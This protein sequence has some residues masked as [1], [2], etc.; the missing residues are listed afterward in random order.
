MEDEFQ[1]NGAK[2]KNIWE[3]WH[4]STASNIL[5]ILKTGYVVPPSNAAHVTGRLYS[6]GVYMSD[7][8]TKSLNYSYGYWSGN[9]SRENCYMFLNDAAMGNYYIPRGQRNS[10]PPSGYDSYYAKE[11]QSGVMNA[12]MIV[13]KT[14]QSNIKYLVVFSR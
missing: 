1:N 10:P 7:I 14:S 8:S 4:G 2:M 13:P 12:E 5:S 6:S 9:R 11:G 3:L